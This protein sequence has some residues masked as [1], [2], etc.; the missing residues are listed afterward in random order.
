M[1]D[2]DSMHEDLARHHAVETSSDRSFG[3]VFAAVFAVIGLWPLVD[4][5]APRWWAIGVAAAVAA[6]AALR[7]AVL[8]PLNRLWTRFGLL[9]HRIVNPL[10][11]GLLFFLVVTPTG[12]LMRLFGKDLLRLRRD[13]A[14]A[15]YWIERDPPGPAPDTMKNQF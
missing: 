2:R 15:S 3:L 6:A 1:T 12:L 14:A 11:M 4:G 13:A 8:A 10:V 5:G 9:L 7:P